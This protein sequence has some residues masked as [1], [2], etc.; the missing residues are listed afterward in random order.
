MISHNEFPPLFYR[1]E[2]WTPSFVFMSF[3]VLLQVRQF[4]LFLYNLFP[5][6]TMGDPRSSLRSGITPIT[7]TQVHRE[8]I[9]WYSWKILQFWSYF[10]GVDPV[11]GR[12]HSDSMVF[13]FDPKSPR[14]GSVWTGIRT[15]P[16]SDVG[17]V[18]PLF[19]HGPIKTECWQVYRSNSLSVPRVFSNTILV[20]EETIG[21][22]RLE[23]LN[24]KI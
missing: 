5:R 18:T 13:Y 2:Y 21:I 1:I 10:T 14:K 24:L 12:P 9:I 22:C 8:R 19:P 15:S 20:Y 23:V 4:T 11:V 17:T 6:S 3:V 7:L 16:D